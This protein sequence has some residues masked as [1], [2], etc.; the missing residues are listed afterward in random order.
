MT[1]TAATR[2]RS[3]ANWVS[4]PLEGGRGFVSS[5][6]SCRAGARITPYLYLISNELA[7]GDV[8]L[9]LILKDLALDI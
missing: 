4:R 2:S 3:L 7:D 9:Y 1:K 8:D 5:R 6:G